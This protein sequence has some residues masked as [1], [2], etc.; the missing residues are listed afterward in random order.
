[1]R[2][3]VIGLSQQKLADKLKIKQQTV[4]NIESGRKQKIDTEILYKLSKEFLI[5]SEWLMFGVG[6]IDKVDDDE[7]FFNKYYNDLV[8]PIKKYDFSLSEKENIDKVIENDKDVLYFD[9]RW[10]RNI[11]GVNPDNIFFIYAPDDSMDSGKNAVNDIKKGD[12]LFIDISQ[13]QGNDKVF[14]YKDDFD[15]IP[16]IRQIKWGLSENTKLIPYNKKYKSEI[17]EKQLND[18]LVDIVGKVV[19]N[20][21]KE[22]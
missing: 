10:L 1:M 19:W 8:T 3:E 21:N 17:I 15:N 12:I 6:N 11:L 9:R 18:F 5:N 2:E 20:S 16:T 22:I 14:V 7:E 4:A 13:K